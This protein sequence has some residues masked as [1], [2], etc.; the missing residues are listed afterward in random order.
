MCQC[1]RGGSQGRSGCVRCADAPDLH[2]SR[3]QPH[4]SSTPAPD[5][6]LRRPLRERTENA[7]PERFRESSL[8]FDFTRVNPV[9]VYQNPQGH[10]GI[11]RLRAAV[12][13][14]QPAPSATAEKFSE[15][16]MLINKVGPGHVLKA[17][18]QGS[19]QANAVSGDKISNDSEHRRAFETM[20]PGPGGKAAS[21]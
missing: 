6:H 8:D 14:R 13:K 16:K 17:S 9:E 21:R 4:Q 7:F 11:Y 12:S 10:F 5:R 15:L 2:V 1:L 3:A 18:R 19:R 20:T